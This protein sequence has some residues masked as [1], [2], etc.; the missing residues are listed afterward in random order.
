M[1]TTSRSDTNIST[2]VPLSTSAVAA[3]MRPAPRPTLPRRRAGSAPGSRSGGRPAPRCSRGSAPA[4]SARG[5]ARGRLPRV[6]AVPG[7]LVHARVSF[8]FDAVFGRRGLYGVPP[9]G[10]RVRYVRQPFA[11]GPEL[12]LARVGR[13]PGAHPVEGRKA[14]RHAPAQPP[15][16]GGVCPRPPRPV[17]RAWSRSRPGTP[18]PRPE[19]SVPAAGIPRVRATPRKSAHFP[20]SQE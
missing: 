16:E 5:R 18:R 2:A 12:V 14:R 6:Q 1:Y 19:G 4:S 20:S 10:E 15:P 9:P 13:H 3:R 17:S 7:V 11:D 8:R